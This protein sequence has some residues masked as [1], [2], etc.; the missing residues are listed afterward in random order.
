[1]SSS[2][3]QILKKN[4]QRLGL[5]GPVVSV[6][7]G[8]VRFCR[9]HAG[10]VHAV[11]YGAASR[12]VPLTANER[13]LLGFRNKHVGARAFII[14]NGPSL[15]ECDLTLLKNE[16][17]FGVN[18]IYLNREKM[19]Y[20]PTYYI[21]EDRFVADDR[22]E[23]I[24]NYQG[25]QGKFFG[26]YLKCYLAGAK[27]ATW[28]NVNPTY[29]EFPGWPL[30]SEDASRILWVGGTVTYISLQ[31]AFYMGISEV[32]MIGFDHN[33]VVPEEDKTSETNILSTRDDVNHFHPDYFGR[34]K[35][36][37]DPRVDRMERCYH[38]AKEHYDRAGRL[39][40]N[41][42]VGGKLEV[43]PRVDYASL[44]TTD[45]QEP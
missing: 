40:F 24:K 15:N 27:D 11:R 43:F 20:D 19:G 36:W 23:E 6:Y 17:T 9:R 35:R 45:R 29:D 28:L 12:G 2:S 26:N 34:G 39:I 13:R 4:L 32:Y 44:F 21:V 18:A 16:I 8:T 14:G 22:A 3:R 7:N 5:Y 1:M 30:F 42:T 10:L 33:Y 38:R 25:P 37:H 31:I 41:A